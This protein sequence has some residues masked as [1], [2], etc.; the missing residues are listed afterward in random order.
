MQSLAIEKR[1]AHPVFL[2][3]RCDAVVRQTKALKLLATSARAQTVCADAELRQSLHRRIQ[4][5]ALQ[6]LEFREMIGPQGLAHPVVL[7]KP[8]P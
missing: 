4:S 8:A 5:L 1:V 3:L 6:I 2:I 7:G